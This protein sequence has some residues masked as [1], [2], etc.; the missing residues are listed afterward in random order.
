MLNRFFRSVLVFSVMAAVPAVALADAWLYGQDGLV[1]IKTH[2]SSECRPNG[3]TIHCT[4]GA[5]SSANARFVRGR[6]VACEFLVKNDWTLVHGDHW[7]VYKKS[8]NCR[9]QFLGGAGNSFN[10]YPPGK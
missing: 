6:D 5:Q 9:L 8:G 3:S 4:I 10:V 1:G 7:N 2:V